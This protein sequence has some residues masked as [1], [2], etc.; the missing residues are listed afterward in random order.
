[1]LVSFWKDKTFD[2]SEYDHYMCLLDEEAKEIDKTGNKTKEGREK[3]ERKKEE[4]KEE[5][6]IKCLVPSDFATMRCSMGRI[7]QAKQTFATVPRT[8]T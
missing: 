1:M 6:K 4:G 2:P 8:W 3:V 5:G 7:M